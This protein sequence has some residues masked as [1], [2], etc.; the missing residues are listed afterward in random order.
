MKLNIASL[1]GVV[2]GSSYLLTSAYAYGDCGDLD[3][4]SSVDYHSERRDLG[5]D[6][7]DARSTVDVSVPFHPSLR[8]FLED[9][10]AAHARRA[11]SP[12][13]EAKPGRTPLLRIK[14]GKTEFDRDFWL[15]DKPARIIERI[16]EDPKW[17]PPSPGKKIVDVQLGHIDSKGKMT[18]AYP[19]ELEAALHIVDRGVGAVDHAQSSPRTLPI[20]NV[21]TKLQGDFHDVRNMR[22]RHVIE[23]MH[24]SAP[25]PSAN[26]PYLAYPSTV[27]SA[28]FISSAP[29]PG[30]PQAGK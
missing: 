25:R 14:G 9:A 7:F 28:P 18:Q 10:A 11:L 5:F 27:P 8:A 23:T 21:N 19:E 24:P 30:V 3:V 12:S 26:S 15:Y 17:I 20:V 16:Q 1:F 13:K 29:A 2:M 22:L 4:R 6:A